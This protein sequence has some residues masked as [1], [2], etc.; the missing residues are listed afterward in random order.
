M[1]NNNLQ[2]NDVLKELEDILNTAKQEIKITNEENKVDSSS[3]FVNDEINIKPN[4]IYEQET[5]V[6]LELDNHQTE[7]FNPVE[8]NPE[9]I[10]QENKLKTERKRSFFSPVI[11]L[12]K[13]VLTSSLLFMVLLVTT[14]YS[15][16]IN[17]A[18]SYIFAWELEATSQK[19]ITSVEASNIKEKYSEEA[20]SNEEDNEEKWEILSIK[21]MKREQD[22][23]SVDLDIEITPYENRIIIPKIWQNIPLI[24]I[25]NRSIDG[26]DELNDI[27][28]KELEKG[29]IRYPG[30]A[31][32][33]ENGSSFIFGHSS[34]FPW[35]KWDYNDVFSLLD[36]VVYNDEVIVYYWQEKYTYKIKEKKVITPWDVSVLERNKDKSEI[37]LM[38][39]WPI[40]TTLNRLI[41]TWE[42][43]E[44]N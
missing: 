17:I 20:K 40:W 33:G 10:I 24:D 11:F 25:K 7:I 28:M 8:Y 19:L 36:K 21:K 34:N 23:K 39:C 30:S 26:Q 14:N 5:N 1:Q 42:L 29:I 22:K 35:I 12:A 6:D 43:I 38:T 27:F 9:E 3:F 13:Y 18:K 15:A 31:K 41:V 16:Y 4:D 2:N 37:T 44:I 32:P